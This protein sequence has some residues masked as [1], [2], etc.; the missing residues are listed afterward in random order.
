LVCS[1]NYDHPAPRVFARLGG[2]TGF[3]REGVAFEHLETGPRGLSLADARVWLRVQR[4]RLLVCGA[5]GRRPDYTGVN[6]TLAARSVGLPVLSFLDHWKGWD[7]FAGRNDP[8]RFLPDSLGVPDSASL[9]HLVGLGLDRRRLFVAGHPWLA[10]RAGRPLDSRV[11]KRIRIQLGI[12]P[13]EP[14]VV[15][16]S[17]PL[18]GRKGRTLLHVRVKGGTLLPDLVAEALK[19]TVGQG[20]LVLRPHPR[21]GRSF[22]SRTRK[23]PVRRIVYREADPEPLLAGADLVIGLDSMFLVEGALR[24]VPA[25]SLGNSVPGYQNSCFFGLG[26]VQVTTPGEL[27][28]AVAHLLNHAAPRRNAP[29][30]EVPDP[31][32]R[33]VATIN[34][35]LK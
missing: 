31:L 7:R 23:H 27:D 26:L 10:S 3:G 8:A 35:L 2:E 11:R 16:I 14:V 12:A 1:L 4:P 18:P 17:Q 34:G 28:R 24:G 20:V 5:S 33:C 6:L 13:D 32:S 22:Q 30:L 15:L 21:E 29:E 19:T 9:D 25:L